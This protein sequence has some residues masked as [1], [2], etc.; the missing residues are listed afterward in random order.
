MVQGGEGVYHG[1][2]EVRQ[3]AGKIKHSSAVKDALTMLGIIVGCLV[4]VAVTLVV[5]VM[6][7]AWLLGQVHR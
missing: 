5:M 3:V 6:G 2:G 4:V 1:V 7:F